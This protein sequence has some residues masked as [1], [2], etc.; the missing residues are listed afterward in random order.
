MTCI[1]HIINRTNT[2]RFGLLPISLYTLPDSENRWELKKPI[3]NLQN[4]KLIWTSFIP[5]LK[6][7]TFHKPIAWKSQQLSS[8]PTIMSARC[9]REAITFFS[10]AWVTSSDWCNVWEDDLNI[11]F[12]FVTLH[13]S[14]SLRTPALVISSQLR[15]EKWSVPSRPETAECIQIYI[16]YYINALQK[17]CVT[18]WNKAAQQT[19]TSWCYGK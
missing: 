14:E 17:T 4:R 11:S 16:R 18:N 8:T 12:S 1:L 10:H 9:P 15:K 3:I 2:F 6:I 13:A 19:L 5:Q 7:T